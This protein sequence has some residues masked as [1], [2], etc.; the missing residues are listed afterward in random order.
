MIIDFQAAFFILHLALICFQIKENQIQV[1][2]LYYIG[3]STWE[4]ADLETN[5][6]TF[7]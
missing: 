3:T 7:A 1:G 6:S 5:L 2:L 4:Q